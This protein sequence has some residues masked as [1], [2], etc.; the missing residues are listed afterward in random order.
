MIFE[1]EYD[2]VTRAQQRYGEDEQLYVQ[3]IMDPYLYYDML[4]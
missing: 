4:L 3:R 1:S 2:G